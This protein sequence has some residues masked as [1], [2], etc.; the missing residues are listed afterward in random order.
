M[1]KYNK[2]KNLFEEKQI[3][4]IKIKKYF[5]IAKNIV[6]NLNFILQN[7]GIYVNSNSNL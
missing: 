4:G 5:L 2:L 1:F 3:K 7:L 6:K